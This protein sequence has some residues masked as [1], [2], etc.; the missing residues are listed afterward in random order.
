MKPST[1]RIFIQAIAI[2]V[3]G[4]AMANLA[5][6]TDFFFCSAIFL[7]ARGITWIFSW[8]SSAFCGDFVIMQ[9]SG[10]PL[11]QITF[12]FAMLLI[13]VHV[14]RSKL[15]ISLKSAFVMISSISIIAVV[16]LLFWR[17]P[18]VGLPL[19]GIAYMSIISIL[20]IKKRP[21]QYIYGITLA[22]AML[23]IIVLTGTEI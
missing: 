19:A 14:V 4:F 17:W 15:W 16:S 21:W 13:C 7:S 18:Y 12:A 20:V 10:M 22:V 23:L 3:L 5:F 1:K 11:V 9:G 6:I 2:P 8:F